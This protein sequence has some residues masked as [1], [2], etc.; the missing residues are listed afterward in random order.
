MAFG[1][2]NSEG[3]IFFYALELGLLFKYKFPR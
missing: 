1:G 2:V 3:P